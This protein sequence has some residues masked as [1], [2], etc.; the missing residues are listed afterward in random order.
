MVWWVATLALA[1]AA[2]SACTKPLECSD[3]EIEGSLLQ[4]KKLKTAE[5]KAEKKKD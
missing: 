3:S 2:T 5:L 4:T 1:A